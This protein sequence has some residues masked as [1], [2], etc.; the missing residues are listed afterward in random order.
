MS[1]SIPKR[2]HLDRRAAYLVAVSDGSPDDL[3]STQAVADWI[4]TSKQFLETARARGYGPCFIQVSPGRI[5]YR[6]ADI[7]KWLDERTV[8]STAEYIE[9]TSAQDHESEEAHLNTSTDSP[10]RFARN[11]ATT[12]DV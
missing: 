2:H 11:A 3:L 9:R 8:A 12:K 4:G 6:R 1:H 7:L 5:R 10:D